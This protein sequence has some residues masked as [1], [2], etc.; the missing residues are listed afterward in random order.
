MGRV[1]CE[2]RILDG[3]GTMTWYAV[4]N[5]T[6]DKVDHSYP[7]F[8]DEETAELFM[9]LKDEYKDKISDEYDTITYKELND[10]IL[11]QVT[12]AQ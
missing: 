9:K 3:T 6:T 4:W 1:L 10:F 8:D 5:N 11:K 2:I 12:E 7:L